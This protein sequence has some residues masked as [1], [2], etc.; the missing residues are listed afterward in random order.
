MGRHRSSQENPVHAK[1]NK[2]HT[3]SRCVA[4]CGVASRSFRALSHIASFRKYMVVPGTRDSFRFAPA[5]HA[6]RFSAAPTDDSPGPTTLISCSLA[7]V[8]APWCAFFILFRWSGRWLTGTART[9]ARWA[10]YVFVVEADCR[11][12]RFR[13]VACVFSI[14]S[15][16][17]LYSLSLPLDL[18]VSLSLS[19]VTRAQLAMRAIRLGKFAWRSSCPL[20]TRQ[21]EPRHFCFLVL[22]V[23]PVFLLYLVFLFFTSVF[24]FL[25]PV[26]FV[27][28]FSDD[29]RLHRRH[30]NENTFVR[31]W[32]TGGREARRIVRATPQCRRLACSRSR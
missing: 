2:S 30:G 20:R 7:G 29:G 8:C 27:F 16:V 11:R 28:L 17:Y 23:T 26:F 10:K 14:S 18:D 22:F 32:G 6:E 4:L 21:S 31:A 25:L 15:S 13:P 12:F 19:W 24:L 5:P 9:R 3:V 1:R